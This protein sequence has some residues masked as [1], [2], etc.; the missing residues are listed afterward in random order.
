M[1]GPVNSR[2]ARAAQEPAEA[3]QHDG[4]HHSQR[5]VLSERALA[6]LEALLA[7]E[8][9]HSPSIAAPDAEYEQPCDDAEPRP[10]RTRGERDHHDRRWSSAARQGK[11]LEDFL[12][13]VK[14]LAAE[15]AMRRPHQISAHLAESGDPESQWNARA[16]LESRLR[17]NERVGSNDSERGPLDWRTRA[18]KPEP[19][20][21]LERPERASR[22]TRAMH[23]AAAVFSVIAAV[24]ISAIVAALVIDGKLPTKVTVDDVARVEQSVAVALSSLVPRASSE[25][26]A[27]AIAGAIGSKQDT[28]RIPAD[29]SIPVRVV[30]TVKAVD[31]Q[32]AAAGAQTAAAETQAPA[33]D[34]RMA[35]V[36]PERVASSGRPRESGD[37]AS[38]ANAQAALESRGS[39]SSVEPKARP[40]GGNV[41][42]EAKAAPDTPS[43][44]T[45]E[46]AAQ[47]ETRTA[48]VTEHVNMRASAKSDAAVVGVVPAGKS[49]EVVSCAQWCEV[50]YDGKQGFVYKKFL[51]GVGG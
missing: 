44:S 1:T 35:A 11:R 15:E 28:S 9:R 25:R 13:E 7:R 22:L 40:E 21:W 26:D 50:V 6:A 38:Q 48:A 23:I 30:R 34:M 17:G 41:R 49:V 3:E 18:L 42:S 10:R 47:T 8:L 45:G 16:A 12:A 33:A 36:E 27:S 29:D 20:P 32:A 31:A 51:S 19:V 46:S 43:S 2:A 39:L 37:A 4:S 14:H 5:T 24:G